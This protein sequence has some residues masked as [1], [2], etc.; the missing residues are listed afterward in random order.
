M[1]AFWVYHITESTVLLPVFSFS[2]WRKIDEVEGE[3]ET[4]GLGNFH[5]YVAVLSLFGRNN[6]SFALFGFM[7]DVFV[8]YIYC[9]CQCD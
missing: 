3:L 1:V 8:T 9:I 4:H 7:R 5:L 6:V 2:P